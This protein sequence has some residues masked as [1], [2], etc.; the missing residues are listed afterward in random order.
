MYLP[1]QPY[2]NPSLPL[3]KGDFCGSDELEQ[4]VFH[5]VEKSEISDGKAARY[6]PRGARNS[7]RHRHSTSLGMP[8]GIGA[9][10]QGRHH[11]GR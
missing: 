3:G 11:I 9:V 7:V 2:S 1:E 8:K 6:L 10:V 5:F 4:D